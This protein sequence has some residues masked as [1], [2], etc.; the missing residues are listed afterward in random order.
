MRAGNSYAAIFFATIGSRVAALGQ[1]HDNVA[2][3]LWQEHDGAR[4]LAAHAQVFFMQRVRWCFAQ[5]IPQ[6]QSRELRCLLHW[7]SCLCLQCAHSCS[8]MAARAAGNARSS[9]RAAGAAWQPSTSTGSSR[10]AAEWRGSATSRVNPT[11]IPSTK[12][13]LIHCSNIR[14]NAVREAVRCVTVDEVSGTV[15]GVACPMLD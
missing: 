4:L 13:T 7:C 10:V 14:G 6:P 12:P 2:T 3:L 8:R 11:T 1:Q 9:T 15:V 5:T